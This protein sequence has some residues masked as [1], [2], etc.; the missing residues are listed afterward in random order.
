MSFFI[1]NA[2]H[3]LWFFSRWLHFHQSISMQPSNS[4]ISWSDLSRTK[5]Q[6][7]KIRACDE[8]VKFT[9]SDFVKRAFYSHLCLRVVVVKE[10]LNVLACPSG[11][12][13][14]NWS[15]ILSYWELLY[16]NLLAWPQSTPR[17]HVQRSTTL[18][19]VFF[20]SFGLLSSTL[21][22]TALFGPF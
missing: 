1:R 21:L 3:I 7:N 20:Y 22:T 14:L 15:V 13:F 4:I 16:A 5:I 6:G 10:T 12:L 19:E 11:N 17:G 8:L 18:F 9:F 2:M